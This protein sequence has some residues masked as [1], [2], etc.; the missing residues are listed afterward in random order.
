MSFIPKA[1]DE[2]DPLERQQKD[3]ERRRRQENERKKRFF[4]DKQRIM[5]L[6]MKG[7]A[8][9]VEEKKQRQ[10]QEKDDDINYCMKC[11]LS[12]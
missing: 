1:L 10:K 7:L 2:R 8:K 5:G 12:H 6:D 9:Q 4:D 3:I 11:F